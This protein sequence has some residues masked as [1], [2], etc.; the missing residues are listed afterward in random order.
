[1]IKLVVQIVKYLLTFGKSI[2]SAR[3]GGVTG[4]HCSPLI[5]TSDSREVVGGSARFWEQERIAPFRYQ[6]VIAV[7]EE[8]RRLRSGGSVRNARTTSFP[9]P[10]F[11]QVE[12]E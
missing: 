10:Y 9:H 2:F 8:S 6:L 11:P 4:S 5:A 12:E 3:S 7:A 1:M